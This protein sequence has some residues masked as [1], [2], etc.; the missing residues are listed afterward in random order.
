MQQHC[1][2]I[3]SKTSSI[4]IEFEK[5][6]DDNSEPD[7]TKY[8]FAVDENEENETLTWYQKWQPIIWKFMEDP[9][10]SAKAKVQYLQ[11]PLHYFS[12]KPNF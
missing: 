8:G 7:L 5:D 3:T 4:G 1:I 11:Q 2:L 6:F 12:G 9:Y 10:S